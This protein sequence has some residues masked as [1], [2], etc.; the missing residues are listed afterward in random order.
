M[1]VYTGN[2]CA[3]PLPVS[4]CV[5]H[6]VLCKCVCIEPMRV[7]TVNSV[8]SFYYLHSIYIIHIVC[9]HDAHSQYVNTDHTCF[10]ACITVH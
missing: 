9:M 5:I 8:H 10:P 4:S 1:H 6:S 3:H 2:G 7:K